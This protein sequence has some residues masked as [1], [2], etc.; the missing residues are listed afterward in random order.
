MMLRCPPSRISLTSSDV[1]GLEHRH[2]GRQAA[3]LSKPKAGNIRLSPGP[4]R[5]TSLSVVTAEQNIG[6]KRAAS[7]SSEATLH[8]DNGQKLDGVACLPFTSNN[9]EAT[10]IGTSTNVQQN[11]NDHPTICREAAGALVPAAHSWQSPTN[12]QLRRQVDRFY[13]TERTSATEEPIALP[14]C[15]TSALSLDGVQE[16]SQRETSV[17]VR[18][19]IHFSTNGRPAL[20]GIN[21][22]AIEERQEPQSE[23]RPF[24]SARARRR[25]GRMQDHALSQNTGDALDS[26]K[27]RSP[28]QL[29]QGQRQ[30]WGQLPQVPELLLPSE[31]ATPLS[32]QELDPGA[33]VFVPRTRFGTGSSVEGVPLEPR[34][35][36]LDSTHSLSNLRIR[37]SSEQ[38]VECAIRI[39]RPL[40]GQ[41]TD[42]ASG[43]ASQS[44]PRRRSRTTDQNTAIP[45]LTPNLERY[46]LLRPPSSLN[47]R[48]R[49]SAFDPL[50]PSP[51]HHSLGAS[52]SSSHGES[53]NLV[54]DQRSL[55]LEISNDY[56]RTESTLNEE[57][58]HLRSASPAISTSSRSTPNLLQHPISPER[59]YSRGS[60]LGWNQAGSRNASFHRVPSM[61]SA[62]SGLSGAASMS[63]QS[64]REG[65][66]AATEFLRKRNSPLDDLTERLS[67]LST[68]RPRS[69]GHSWERPP[70][71]RPRASLLAGDPFKPE[72]QAGLSQELRIRHT[73]L[74]SDRYEPTLPNE[75]ETT[76]ADLFAL[77]IALPPSSPLPS[78][79]PN[80][81]STPP[82]RSSVGTSSEALPTSPAYV[83]TCSPPESSIKRKPVPSATRTPKMT[84][85]DDSKPPNTQ[86]QTPADV[87][88][89]NR[90]TKTR[91][92]TAVA[93]SPISIGRTKI[94]SP[95][96][97]PERNPH[98]ST[99]PPVS[100][101]QHMSSTSTADSSQTRQAPPTQTPAGDHHVYNVRQARTNRG[102]DQAEN[103][104]EG[105]LQRSESDRRTWI[106]R[107][108]GGDLESTPPKE[109]R[110]ERFLS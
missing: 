42:V 30:T 101:M 108:G 64:S 5:Q 91:S 79:P 34:W 106:G 62:A 97:I 40:P 6:R 23:P 11:R 71:N 20:G 38:N 1:A 19:G 72:P 46:P 7:S 90:R 65:L 21:E 49:I 59:I 81:P 61:V 107:R 102:S 29:P 47:A 63:R 16:I 55:R 94:S 10:A 17:E 52:A 27:L 36:S 8:D 15:A 76:A 70:S 56:G 54:F 85:Y 53:E 87:S 88:R 82:T 100:S 83:K 50:N 18:L 35:S 104:V 60:S 13:E 9:A 93:D 22:Q 3:R 84:V 45:S 110:F 14:G 12:S 73:P 67:R 2:A 95:P 96:V 31:F 69:V 25:H 77:S 37:S 39:H 80:L 66:D 99:Y 92:D 26:S 58:T 43:A 28:A 109:G 4:G 75:N 74:T 103:E 24:S 89:T 105:N 32:N 33:P 86:P 51:T 78:S 41:P 98:R 68:S 57:G 44:R 48:R